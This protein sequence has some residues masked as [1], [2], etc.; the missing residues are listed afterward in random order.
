MNAYF[1]DLELFSAVAELGFLSFLGHL[2]CL[3]AFG[4]FGFDG[5]FFEIVLH[6]THPLTMAVA[7]RCVL[8]FQSVCP[9]SDF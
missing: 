6:K 8:C 2:S 7:L 4:L 5:C 3:C 9:L 1:L